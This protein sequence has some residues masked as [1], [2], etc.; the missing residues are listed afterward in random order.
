MV[1]GAVPGALGGIAP[2]GPVVLVVVLVVPGAVVVPVAGAVPV[3]PVA[4]GG[5]IGFV[6]SL[7]VVSLVVVVD[8]AGP[9]LGASLVVVVVVVLG[10]C[11][12]PHALRPTP[13]RSAASKR[14]YLIIIPFQKIR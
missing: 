3:V 1:P 7:V 5:V 14:E 4:G 2:P 13:I 8:V 9:F 10:F 6:P 11:W 12:S